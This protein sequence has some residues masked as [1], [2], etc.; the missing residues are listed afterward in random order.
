MNNGHYNQVN[1]YA[2][3]P[4]NA[5]LGRCHVVGRAAPIR[6][7]EKMNITLQTK[8]SPVPRA[9]NAKTA[10]IGYISATATSA[11]QIKTLLEQRIKKQLE[12]LYSVEWVTAADSKT[13]FR[14]SY[15]NGWM[16]EI[17]SPGR[18]T[19]C[20]CYLADNMDELDAREAMRKHA[21]EY[22]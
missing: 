14:L 3:L 18:N 16:Y 20:A 21:S 22:L 2:A 1:N 8:L 13:L 5:L 6:G 9:R 17:M 7:V 15:R 10:H 19:P 4:G 11:A 12:E